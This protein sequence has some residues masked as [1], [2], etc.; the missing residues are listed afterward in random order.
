MR[1]DL[2]V[3]LLLGSARTLHWFNP[4]VYLMEKRA[5]EDME[6]LCDSQVVRE[7]TKEEKKHYSE[8]L[9]ECAAQRKD[10]RNPLFSS[11]FSKETKTLRERFANIFNGQGKKKG[12]FA[13]VLGIGI[14]LFA[15]LFVAFSSEK[16]EHPITADQTEAPETS[17]PSA[18]EDENRITRLPELSIEEAATAI[19]G[20]VFLNWPMYP[21]EGRFFMITG[22]C[23]YIM[24]RSRK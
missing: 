8:M 4:L 9:L 11:E 22:E 5:A 19:Y 24:W 2:L 23:L 14:I 16:K 20:A 3:K 1:K 7:F 12:I 15:S 6:L 21:L 10:G 13:A 17:K 18:R